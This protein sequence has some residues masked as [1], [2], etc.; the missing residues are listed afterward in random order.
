MNKSKIRKKYLL[1][2]QIFKGIEVTE[3][4][5]HSTSKL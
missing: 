1:M 4:L 3:D 5:K 2:F